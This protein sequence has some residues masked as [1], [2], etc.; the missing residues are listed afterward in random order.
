MLKK[1]INISKSITFRELSIASVITALIIACV[2]IVI[3][4]CLKLGD[5]NIVE[6]GAEEIIEKVI[7]EDIDLTP[8]S[9]ES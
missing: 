8:N 4:K 7:G 9:P 5:D 3:G 2:A 6:E 1:I